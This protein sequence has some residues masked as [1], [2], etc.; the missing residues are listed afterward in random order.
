MEEIGVWSVYYGK[1]GLFPLVEY[2][3]KS[4]VKAVIFVKKNIIPLAS[5]LNKISYS[6]VLPKKQCFLSD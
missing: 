1:Y 4:G 2:E 6:T 5:G 3:S